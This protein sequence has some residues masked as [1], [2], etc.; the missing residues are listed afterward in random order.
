MSFVIYTAKRLAVAM[1]EHVLYPM[2]TTSKHL[3]NTT[4]LR[5]FILAYSSISEHYPGGI[6]YAPRIQSSLIAKTC[7]LYCGFLNQRS[8]L[9][10]HRKRNPGRANR[11]AD[12]RRTGVAFPHKKRPAFSGYVPAIGGHDGNQN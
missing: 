4:I 2:D 6:N 8:G 5:D 10:F 1:A 12:C 3:E 11:R 7:A 9:S